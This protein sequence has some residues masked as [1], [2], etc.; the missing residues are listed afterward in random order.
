MT[1]L[2]ERQKRQERCE[3]P[4]VVFTVR[5]WINLSRK[6]VDVSMR[7][8]L[9]H[10]YVMDKGVV[11]VIF[12][13]KCA[14][15]ARV[16]IRHRQRVIE[17]IDVDENKRLW[18]LLWG[19]RVEWLKIWRRYARQSISSW[20]RGFRAARQQPL[21]TACSECKIP[22]KLNFWRKTCI[23]IKNSYFA[24]WE[25]VKYQVVSCGHEGSPTMSSYCDV[26]EVVV[27]FCLLNA[28]YDG[29][30]L[31]LKW[32]WRRRRDYPGSFTLILG[33]CRLHTEFKLI[34]HSQVDI[35]SNRPLLL[36]I[37]WWSWLTWPA[38]SEVHCSKRID[39]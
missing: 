8:A 11:F 6:G 7:C 15:D 18:L 4:L 37:N 34:C 2:K 35:T 26:N 31:F 23:L 32:S 29:E 28:Y 14:P 19:P 24:K 3:A 22:N 33:A 16:D 5:C 20:R 13:L 38:K 25:P 36:H 1:Y 9:W 17:W 12:K 21:H 30:L 39:A 10:W 27:N